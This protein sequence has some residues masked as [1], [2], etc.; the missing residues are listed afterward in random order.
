MRMNTIGKKGYGEYTGRPPAPLP[1]RFHVAV[2][3]AKE[4]HGEGKD[5]A[6]AVEFTVLKGTTPGQEGKIHTEFFTINDKQYNV[7][8]LSRLAMVLVLIGPNEDKDVD[9]GQAK[10]R[11][12]IIEI[13][14]EEKKKKN[15]EGKWETT[16][17]KRLCIPGMSYWPV[18]DKDVADVP[19]DN[20][21]LT[22]TPTAAAGST[23]APAAQASVASDPQKWDV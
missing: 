20:A 8:R 18:D 5:P 4:M 6:M 2:S 17:E 22:A 23:S 21:M 1:G 7:D 13:K 15:S 12:L 16:G 9:F 14:E 11:Q 10:G 19:K 3:D